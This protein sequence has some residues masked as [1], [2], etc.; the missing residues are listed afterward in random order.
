MNFQPLH[1]WGRDTF[2]QKNAR[3]RVVA[4]V[5]NVWVVVAIVWA[6]AIVDSPLIY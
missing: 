1:G 5:G 2:P 6:V 3:Q 4:V